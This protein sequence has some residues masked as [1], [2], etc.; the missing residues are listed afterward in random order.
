MNL[1]ILTMIWVC[2]KSLSKSI[3]RV[4]VGR[5]IGISVFQVACVNILTET[6]VLV[7]T[8]GIPLHTRIVVSIE[9]FG[10]DIT[11]HI[12]AMAVVGSH[13]NESILKF[14]NLT[15]MID[16]G[17]DSVV[18]L[19]EFAKSSI[20]VERVHLFI[21]RGRFGHDEPTGIVVSTSPSL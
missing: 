18:K 13:D 7:S 12:E 9:V 16:S 20:V 5:K 6:A 21:D 2:S 4:P 3:A 10:I 14:S 15:E 11:E 17:F 1:V 8:N 19:E